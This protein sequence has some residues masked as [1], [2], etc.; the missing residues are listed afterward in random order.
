LG[1]PERGE[2]HAGER[3]LMPIPDHQWERDLG[4]ANQKHATIICRVQII[5]NADLRTTVS[6]DARVDAYKLQQQT[7]AKINDDL[8]AYCAMCARLRA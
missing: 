6:G 2:A 5:K 3:S 7:R 4:D 1:K 8:D